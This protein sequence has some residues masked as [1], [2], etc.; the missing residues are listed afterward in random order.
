MQNVTF[1]DLPE[2]VKHLSLQVNE[3]RNFLFNSIKQETQKV[4]IW[5]DIDEL[6][7]YLPDKPAKSTVYSWVNKRLIPYHKN[8]KKLRFLKSEIDKWLLDGKI[9]T[10]TEINQLAS[11]E[12]DIFL[13]NNVGGKI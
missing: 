2:A 3:I 10:H 6:C 5:F 9:E 7:Q 13:L 11:K 12:R 4:E 1:N 8:G